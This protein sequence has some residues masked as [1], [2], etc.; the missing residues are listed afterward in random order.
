MRKN[1]ISSEILTKAFK[2]MKSQKQ[3]IPSEWIYSQT[4]NKISLLEEISLYL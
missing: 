2:S 1:K 4:M 3:K